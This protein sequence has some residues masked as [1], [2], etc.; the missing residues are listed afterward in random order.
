VALLDEGE[1]LYI[2]V[3]GKGNVVSGTNKTANGGWNGGGNGRTYSSGSVN[4]GSGGGATHFAT[5]TGT[6]AS[7]SSNQSAVIMVAGGGGGGHF[8]NQWNY[9]Q[10]GNAGGYIGGCG[11][12]YG[13]DNLNYNDR[14]SQGGTQLAG[15]TNK[16]GGM[17][18]SFGQGFSFTGS[19]GVGGGG[20]GGWYGG[21]GANIGPGGSGSG[22]IASNK[23]ETTYDNTITKHMTGYAAQ[24]SSDPDTRTQ[25]EYAAHWCCYADSECRA[26]GLARVTFLA[27]YQP[28]TS[29]FNTAALLLMMI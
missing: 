3:G 15:G 25:A 17:Q 24:T 12:N 10:G 7:L 5:A 6:L 11:L 16:A 8:T 14:Q 4:T 26:S 29:D 20:G 18:G 23:L 19:N 9:G 27:P 13:S 2:G 22:Y 28:P 21:S 1:T